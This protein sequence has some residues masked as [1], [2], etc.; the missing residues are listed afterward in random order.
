MVPGRHRHHL[1]M[2]PDIP[3]RLLVPGSRTLPLPAALAPAAATYPSRGSHAAAAAPLQQR[4]PAPTPAA[5]APAVAEA[6]GPGSRGQSCQSQ[7]YARRDRQIYRNSSFQARHRSRTRAFHL[8]PHAASLTV[9]P[10]PPPGI[11][12]GRPLLNLLRRH[13]RTGLLSSFPGRRMAWRAFLA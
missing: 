10:I 12:W 5:A 6:E 3:S 13:R 4:S 11:S 1:I 2:K 7:C 9:L 8:W